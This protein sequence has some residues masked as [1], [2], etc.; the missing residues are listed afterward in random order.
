VSGA[1]AVSP[2]HDA[3]IR[4]IRLRSSRRP[5]RG[6]SGVRDPTP[7]RV[8]FALLYEGRKPLGVKRPHPANASSTGKLSAQGKPLDGPLR[9]AKDAGRGG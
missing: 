7:L 6:R 1:A 2:R 3:L 9:H 4:G 8:T 5:R